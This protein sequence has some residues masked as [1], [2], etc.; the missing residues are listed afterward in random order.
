MTMSNHRLRS[1]VWHC[2]RSQRQGREWPCHSIVRSTAGTMADQLASAPFRCQMDAMAISG[3]PVFVILP[4]LSNLIAG[5]YGSAGEETA[6]S[7]DVFALDSVGRVTAPSSRQ[8]PKQ[9]SSI[10]LFHYP[11]YFLNSSPC[12]ISRDGSLPFRRTMSKPPLTCSERHWRRDSIRNQ[13]FESIL[14]SIEIARHSPTISLC[15]FHHNF[16]TED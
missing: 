6:N 2:D 15:R 1:V 14:G 13:I 7:T 11:V 3:C 9:P 10:L 8:L 12:E 4:H 16:S 5:F